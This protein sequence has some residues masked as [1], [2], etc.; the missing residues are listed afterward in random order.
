VGCCLAFFVME[1]VC[2]REE[3]VRVVIVDTRM[4]IYFGLERKNLT[5]GICDVGIVMFLERPCVEK[6]R[7]TAKVSWTQKI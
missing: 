1:R 3:R 6:I 5:A 7:E 4:D 2:G